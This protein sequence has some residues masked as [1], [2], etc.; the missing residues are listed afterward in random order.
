MTIAQSKFKPETINRLSLFALIERVY[1]L[2]APRAYS[3][4]MF[5]A[6]FC[7][8]AVKLFHSYRIGL[9]GKYFQWILSDIAV[10]LFIETVL[11][12]ICFR[13]PNK[14]VMRGAIGT[15]AVVC[16]WS[17]MNAGWLIRT[18]TQILPHVLLPLFRDPLNA[19][20]M[21]GYNLATMPAVA[22]IL[23]GP[24]AVALTFFFCVF[25][26]PPL[27]IHRRRR[28]INKMVI[29]MVIII[30]AV[31][32]GGAIARHGPR[33]VTSAGL[34]YNCQLRAVVSL[35]LPHFHPD[36]K[37]NYSQAKRAIASFDE[38]QLELSGQSAPGGYNV[39]VVVLEGIQYN[40]T[41]LADKKENLTPYLGSV[42]E[43][44]VEFT[45][46]RSLVTH[47]TKALFALLTGRFPSISQD[48]AE[49]VPANKPY[50]S[51][52]VILKS[53]LN[54]RTAFFQSAKGNFE[55]RAGLVCNLGFDKFWTRE[56]LNDPNSYLGYLASDELEMVEPISQWIK[57][58]SRPFFLT[59]LCSVT[60]DPYEVPLWFAEPAKDTIQR[61]RQSVLYTDKFLSSLDA[62]LDRLNV[63]DKTIF[64]IIGDHG[65]AFGE[66]G[67]AGHERISFE[68]VLRVPFCLRV[69][70]LSERGIR[71]T[72]PVSSI[73]LTP[74][75]LSLLGFD[76]SNA[77]LDGINVLGPIPQQRKVF[78]SGWL[79]QSPS[80]FV[81]A[82]KKYVYNPAN[83]KVSVYDLASDPLELAHKELTQEQAK[84]IADEIINW[85]NNSIFKIDQK[86]TGSKTLFGS[87]QCRWNNRIASSKYS[88]QTTVAGRESYPQTQAD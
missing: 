85:R 52:A 86:P 50:A 28:F 31:V 37:I 79:S 7:I 13:W 15:S 18:G 3:V 44:G 26:R 19:L 11:S 69:P 59:V 39:V 66:H 27:P 36:A 74:S 57:S 62:E 33:P 70:F 24:S 49:A 71:I 12:V 64:C 4:L 47:T 25:A 17:V 77:G 84:T 6:L 20:V 21:I 75:L 45:N 82:E 2:L 32:T 46:T 9:P 48:I 42:A 78:F 72:E 83:K 80:G 14:W 35:F 81:T 65:E 54:Y 51:L 63:K 55:A 34:G 43:E 87:W 5:C 22:V 10:L 16:T 58:D 67:L 40:Y 41:S 60:H 56:D 29:C 1:K 73:D 8:L 68:E 61:Y 30:A 23:L 76:I 53:K 38:V 88:P